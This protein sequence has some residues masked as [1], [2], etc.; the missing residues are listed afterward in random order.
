MKSI[1]TTVAVLKLWS[2]LKNRMSYK[3]RKE[4]QL[5]PALEATLAAEPQPRHAFC[6]CFT[7]NEI[8]NK[9]IY[10]LYG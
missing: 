2:E 9:T 7:W 3:F 8:E 4:T 10:A 1:T 5:N 6:V